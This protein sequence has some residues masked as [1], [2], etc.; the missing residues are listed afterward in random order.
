LGG[1]FG[2]KRKTRLAKALRKHLGGKKGRKG[3]LGIVEVDCLSI[4]PKNA[5]T[6]VRSDDLLN[7]VLVKPG[8]PMEKVAEA[9]RTG[10]SQE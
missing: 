4:C 8:M 9:L 1:G 7:W 10:S 5:V 2:P 3:T 6:V